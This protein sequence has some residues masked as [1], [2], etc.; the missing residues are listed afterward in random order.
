M[1]VIL[2]RNDLQILAILKY[3]KGHIL[4]RSLMNVMFVKKDLMTLVIWR[5]IKNAYSAREALS[6]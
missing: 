4:E 1:N 6:M 3:M 5:D 2:V